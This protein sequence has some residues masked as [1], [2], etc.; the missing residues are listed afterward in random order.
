MRFVADSQAVR[1]L[2]VLPEI[3]NI[4]PC[5]I[6]GRNG[7]GKT[8]LIRLLELISGRQPFQ[9][10]ERQWHSL[11]ERLGRTVVRIEELDG[12]RTLEFTFTPERWLT[13]GKA[14]L[15]FDDRLGEARLDGDAITVAEAH[16]LLWVE[17]IAGNEDL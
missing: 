6:E 11:R 9:D 15:S 10:Q 3:P 5:L 8:I 12:G 14:P 13:S 16:E 1:G 17:R 2:R 7:I 4:S